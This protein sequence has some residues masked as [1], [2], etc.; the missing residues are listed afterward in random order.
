MDLLQNPTS[1]AIF[2]KTQL[3][4]DELLPSVQIPGFKYLELT[5]ADVRL[6]WVV[7]EDGVD[8]QFALA[9]LQDLQ[10]QVRLEYSIYIS[11]FKQLEINSFKIY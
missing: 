8:M 1:K 9:S 5:D 11:F 7:L 6:G 3:S 10:I 2:F 4:F